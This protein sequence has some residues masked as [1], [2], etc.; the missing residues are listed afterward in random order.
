MEAVAEKK[1]LGRPGLALCFLSY[2]IPPCEHICPR[3]E[4][5]P[6]PKGAFTNISHVQLQTE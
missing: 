4:K 1:T 2:V 5:Q 6:S 3:H